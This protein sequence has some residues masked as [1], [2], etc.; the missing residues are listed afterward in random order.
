M[1]WGLR[2][3][4]W[5]TRLAV[6]ALVVAVS[7]I[8]LQ[9][10]GPTG[11]RLVGLI[12]AKHLTPVAKRNV[13]WMLG[14]QTL[15]DVSSWADAIRGDQNGTAPWH[16]ADIPPDATGY[17][18]DRD[19]PTQPGVKAGTR[20]D[21]WRDCVVD[22]INYFAEM[23]GDLKRDRADR[24]T[25]LKYLVHFIGDL[26]QPMHSIGVARGG[27]DILVKVFGN[28]NCGNDPARPPLPCNLHS[29]WDGM[30]IDRH[31]LDEA[32]YVALLE[33]IVTAKRLMSQPEGQ[34][35]EWIVESWKLAKDALVAN[36]ANIDQAY[37]DKHIQ[38]ID[39][40]IAIAGT[41]LALVLNRIFSTPP[42]A[43]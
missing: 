21:R 4:A 43:D 23:A 16:F 27:N 5:K 26:H 33:K 12:A 6:S 7:T 37:Y 30:L 11:H 31:K 14:K 42:P 39:N 13:T 8:S 41:R 24:G 29:V 10:W 3:G 17:D 2:L 18:R 34:S 32:A 9:G 35:S 36:D 40:Q 28:A 20:G 1:A 19:C 22:R 38:V 25:A 15:A